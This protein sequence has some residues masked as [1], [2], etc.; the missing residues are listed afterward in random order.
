MNQN[1]FKNKENYRDAFEQ[2]LVK[3]LDHE[4][5]GV[6]I[7][8]L[9]N[10]HFD[11]HVHNFTEQALQKKYDILCKYFRN[12]IMEGL[13]LKCPEDDIF[14]FLKLFAIKLEGIR[15]TEFRQ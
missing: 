10:A 13:P 9:A 7:L 4:D 5:L 1:I 3:L 8:V 6:F 12:A 14:V 2:G 15:Q 11:Q